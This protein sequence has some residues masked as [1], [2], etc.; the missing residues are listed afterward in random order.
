[1]QVI[2]FG[3]VSRQSVQIDKPGGR[4]GAIMFDRHDDAFVDV[5]ILAQVNLPRL[6][7]GEDGMNVIA[8]RQ[9]APLI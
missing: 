3:I 4:F 1:M 6:V 5:G 9:N 8:L 2:N 7:A